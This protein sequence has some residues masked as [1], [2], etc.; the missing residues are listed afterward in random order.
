MCTIERGE[1]LGFQFNP[2]MRLNLG[3]VT[4]PFVALPKA[5]LHEHWRESQNP[6]HK[7]ASG[8]SCQN[9]TVIKLEI[10]PV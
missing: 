7:A 2:P 1:R 4:H 8:H 3:K 6:A 5:L 10:P 9:G